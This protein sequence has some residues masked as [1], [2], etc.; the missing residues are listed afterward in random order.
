MEIEF[1]QPTLENRDEINKYL[2][3]K[4][5]RSCELTFANV[6]LWSRHYPVE[7]AIVCDTLVFKSMEHDPT[8]CFPVG[9]P[10]NVKEAI[11]SIMAHSADLGRNFHMHLVTPEQFEVL[12]SLYPGEFE[13]E[14]NRD[15]ADYVYES[16]KLA[17]LSGKKYHGKKNH[18]NKFKRLYPDWVYESITKDNLEDCFQMAI[19]WRNLNGC[20]ADPEKHA[21]ICVTLNSL[22]L[23]EELELRGGLLRVHGEVVAFCLAEPICDDTIV[24]HIEKAYADIEGAYPMINQQFVQHEAMEFKYVNREDDVGEEGLRRAKLSYH[25]VFLVEKGLV[26]RK[27]A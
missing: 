20:E 5:T 2:R 9:E 18:V 25:P 17:N 4:K 24:V 3:R 12:E 15:E 7:Y 26:R 10:E 13:I 23:F 1:K 16:E 14:Y 21:E 27:K 8:Y 19:K 11:D 6:Y 22:R